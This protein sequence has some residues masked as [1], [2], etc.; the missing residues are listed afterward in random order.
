MAESSKFR[1]GDDVREE[2]AKSPNAD[3]QGRMQPAGR[4]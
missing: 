4:A 2:R 1:E 3:N